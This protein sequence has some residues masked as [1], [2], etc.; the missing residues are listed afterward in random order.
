MREETMQALRELRTILIIILTI[1]IVA[2][3]LISVYYNMDFFSALMTFFLQ[4]L[5]AGTSDTIGDVFYIVLIFLSLGLT[6]YMFEKVIFLLS[7]LRIGGFLMSMRLSSMKNHYIVCGAGRVGMHA[8][9][10]LKKS[11]R[12]VVV[13]DNDCPRI[14]FLKRR[15]YTVLAGDCVNEEVLNK[16]KIKTAKGILACTNDDSKNVFLILTSKDLNPKIKIAARV[17]D[18]SSQAEFE[19]A[20]ADVIVAPEITGGREIADK[21]TKL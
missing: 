21:I 18:H 14:E 19:R 9:E 1:V 20:G 12:K 10:K 2:T 13:I 16:A 17:N 5:T 6:F 4:I 7:E 8:A 11:G 3:F 15:G